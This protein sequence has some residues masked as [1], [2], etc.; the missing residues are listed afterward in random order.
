MSYVGTATRTIATLEVKGSKPVTDDKSY[1]Y[2]AGPVKASASGKCVRY[3]GLI[4]DTRV[5]GEIA[6]GGRTTFGN[7]G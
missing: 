6:Q 4:Y 1:K 2:Y 3:S 5:Q 7:C